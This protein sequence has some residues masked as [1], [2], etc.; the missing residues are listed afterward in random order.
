MV[1]NFVSSDMIRGHIDTIILLSLSDEDKHSNE[2]REE[3]EKKADGKYKVKQGTFYSALQ[4]LSKQGLITEY[5]SSAK[6]SIRRKY[7]HLTEKGKKYVED[8]ISQ[9]NYSRSVINNMIFNE[10]SE[11]DEIK[12]EN[13]VVNEL[14]YEFENLIRE[15]VDDYVLTEKNDDLNEYFD[16]LN[17]TLK[18]LTPPPQTFYEDP[19]LDDFNDEQIVNNDINVSDNI[20]HEEIIEDEENAY[21]DEQS[22]NSHV[23]KFY[24]LNDSELTEQ[25]TENIED[26]FIVE[27][28]IQTKADINDDYAENESFSSTFNEN[29]IIIEN[30]IEDAIPV[31]VDDNEENLLNTSANDEIDVNEKT[32]N[33]NSTRDVFD[34]ELE[35]L[36]NK[37]TTDEKVEEKFVQNDTLPD[38]SYVNSDEIL[39]GKSEEKELYD[40]LLE[41]LFPKKN[42]TPFVNTQFE[43]KYSENNQVAEQ[44]VVIEDEE[45]VETTQQ[46]TTRVETSYSPRNDVYNPTENISKKTNNSGY[47][48]PPTRNEKFDYSDVLKLARQEGFKVRAS[49]SASL[50]NKEQ[51]IFINKLNLHTSLLFFVAFILELLVLFLTIKFNQGFSVW[52][53]IISLI[54]FSIVP[55]SFWII[56]LKNKNKTVSNINKFRDSIEVVFIIALNLILLICAIAIISDINFYSARDLLKYLIIP[57]IYVLNLPLFFI[58]K[59]ILLEKKGYFN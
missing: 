24:E 58:I 8:N 45:K 25:S 54:A 29:E 38:N 43:D 1:T 14:Q 39:F 47:Y 44:K 46:T 15:D 26:S 40:S 12:T 11:P 30:T 3:I 50:P 16:K 23:A 41:K 4:R 35:V 18:E 13:V 51:K 17:N 20:V 55:I 9:W 37:N 33:I 19:V 7:F 32:D 28:E 49:N 22:E 59:Y 10:N 48:Y 42:Q 53:Y 57:I 27:N 36:S 56:Y 34:L 21:K 31:I 6:D 52:F 2:I 5:R